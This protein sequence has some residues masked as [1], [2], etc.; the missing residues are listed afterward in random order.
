MPVACDAAA[1]EVFTAQRPTGWRWI[2]PL[3]TAMAVA[4]A[5]RAALPR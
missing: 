3:V 4:D 1:A 2:W 5:W